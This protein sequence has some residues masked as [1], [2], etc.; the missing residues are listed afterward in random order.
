MG[1][2]SNTNDGLADNLSADTSMLSSHDSALSRIWQIGL[3]T[4]DPGAQK[5]EMT[6]PRSQGGFV[7]LQSQ[8]IEGKDSG[9]KAHLRSNPSSDSY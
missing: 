3:S 2:V 5:D 9:V 1:M 7:S 6:C 8:V 4:S